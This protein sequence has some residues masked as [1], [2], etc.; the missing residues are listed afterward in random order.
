MLRIMALSPSSFFLHSCKTGDLKTI[1]T[2]LKTTWESIKD[3]CDNCFVTEEHYNVFCQLPGCIVQYFSQG[4]TV[5]MKADNISSMQCILSFIIQT[6]DAGIHYPHEFTANY[7]YEAMKLRRAVATTFLLKQI[8]VLNCCYSPWR[9]V[10]EAFRSGDKEIAN[11]ALQRFPSQSDGAMAGAC[12]AADL[13]LMAM[14]MEHKIT[15]IRWDDALFYAAKSGKRAAVNMIVNAGQIS[16][17]E[18]GLRGACWSGNARLVHYFIG[19]GAHDWE[20]GLLMACRI[21]VNLT[22]LMI[23]KGA[24]SFNLALFEITS[25][26]E[27]S[28]ELF[29]ELLAVILPYHPLDMD[30]MLF[31][32]HI[33]GL[34]NRNFD[35]KHFE[36]TSI[37][38]YVNVV[39]KNHR[40]EQSGIC[41]CLYNVLPVPLIRGL[42]Y[43]YMSYSTL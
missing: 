26:V 1:T 31:P 10:F 32:H 24:T 15:E 35:V 39:Q 37:E 30:G 18:N 16:D 17:W 7:L 42:I 38:E 36:G 29:F 13:S 41:R 23:A 5:A 3:D 8:V 34:M 40:R 12:E 25:V 19:K 6:A 22:R 27:K 9:I 4:M 28:S 14:L 20:Q 33:V 21:S 11:L 43:P 2:I